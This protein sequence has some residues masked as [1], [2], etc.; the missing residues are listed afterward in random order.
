MFSRY[1]P[2]ASPL[3]WYAAG[4]TVRVGDVVSW[5]QR[6]RPLQ[7][8]TTLDTHQATFRVLA[9]RRSRLISRNVCGTDRGRSRSYFTRV[10]G[11]KCLGFVWFLKATNLSAPRHCVL[12]APGTPLSLQVVARETSCI[13][14]KIKKKIIARV[15]HFFLRNEVMRGKI[16]DVKSNIISY[17]PRR[18]SVHNHKQE[19]GT[20]RINQFQKRSQ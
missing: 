12:L 13:V 10:T 9:P 7:T 5:D 3:P 11:W 16:Q 2:G 1:L 15:I 19:C 17:T 20:S 18:M 4:K 14:C 6:W 8:S